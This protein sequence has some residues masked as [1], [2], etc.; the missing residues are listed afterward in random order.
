LSPYSEDG[1]LDV[2][3][4]RI[5]QGNEANKGV[6]LHGHV[7]GLVSVLVQGF[8][9]NKLAL[10]KGKDTLALSGTALERSLERVGE[11]VVNGVDVAV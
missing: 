3:A 4:R 5:D 7:H 2:L 10:G 11:S 9:A 6:V 1:L 8:R